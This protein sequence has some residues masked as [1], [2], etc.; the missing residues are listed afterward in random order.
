V[1]LCTGK[2]P[3]GLLPIQFLFVSWSN[4]KSHSLFDKHSFRA[5]NVIRNMPWFNII[6]GPGKDFLFIGTWG[7]IVVELA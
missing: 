2:A 5:N 7:T 1:K 3:D 4:V 6:L